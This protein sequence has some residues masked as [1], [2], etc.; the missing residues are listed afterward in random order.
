MKREE[1]ET[2]KELLYIYIVIIENVKFDINMKYKHE[3]FSK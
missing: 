2:L 3:I 1:K